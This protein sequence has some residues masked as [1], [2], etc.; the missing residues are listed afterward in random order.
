MP[1]YRPLTIC[2]LLLTLLLTG[3]AS[4]RPSDD[5][6][7]G[8][9]AEKLYSE[10]RRAMDKKGYNQAIEY[11]EKLEARFPYGKY[12]LQ[13]QLDLAY[14]YYKNNDPEAGIEAADRFIT[15]HP[16]HPSVDY[17]YYLKGLIYFTIDSSL[18]DRLAPQDSSRRDMR[19]V[20]Q[21]FDAF[22][23]LLR[24]FPESQYVADSQQRMIYLRNQM[25][26]Q[27][28]HIAR[29]YMKRGAYLA[30]ANRA[31][32]VVEAYPMTPSSADG[33]A[34]MSEAYRL[35]GMHELATDSAR[36]LSLNFP[37][38]PGSGGKF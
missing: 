19:H 21:S 29:F 4:D 35:L 3:C 34:I 37:N 16:V 31:R 9:S 30:A 7:E 25:A 15:L 23:L 5:R 17:A 26:K 14:A 13:G 22:G 24:R 20:K 28:I 27:E 12:A 1:T 33:L 8:W 18:I 2:F 32:T 10:A 11:Y 36:V 6:T 38:H